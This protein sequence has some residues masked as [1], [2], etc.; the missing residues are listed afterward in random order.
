MD[1]A[2]HELKPENFKRE[3]GILCHRIY[4]KEES[5]TPFGATWCRVEPG[6]STDPHDHD[7]G[8]T[9]FIMEGAGTM[10]IRGESN[11]VKKGDTVFIPPLSNHVLKN[12]SQEDE[13]VFL[14]VY[15]ENKQ[16]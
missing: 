11:P 9:F 13:L 16:E 6:G 2:I 7:E 1:P 5:P 10:T 15:W 4:P 14:S 3:Y 12:N 8:E